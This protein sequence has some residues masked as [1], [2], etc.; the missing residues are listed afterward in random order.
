M[1]D[2][3]TGHARS[4]RVRGKAPGGGPAFPDRRRSNNPKCP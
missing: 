3:R 2:H 1:K 4:M